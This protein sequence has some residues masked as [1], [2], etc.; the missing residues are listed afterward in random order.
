L[1]AEP[2]PRLRVFL[3]IDDCLLYKREIYHNNEESV[4]EQQRNW[5]ALGLG[6]DTVVIKKGQSNGY[7]FH[8]FAV[9]RPGLSEFLE[10]ANKIADLYVFSG[11][12]QWYVDA[13]VEQAIDP[14]SKYIKKVFAWDTMTIGSCGWYTKDLRKLGDYYD[15]KRSVLIDNCPHNLMLQPNN[16][17]ISANSPAMSQGDPKRYLDEDNLIKKTALAEY[18]LKERNPLSEVL[19]DLQSVASLEDVRPYLK[20]KYQLYATELCEERYKSDYYRLALMGIHPEIE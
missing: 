13:V 14:N 20:K 5:K 15:P 10:E 17:I 19:T 7:C 6:H 11:M 4:V 18:F 16:G 9:L 2:L 3:D 1:D 12:G 8:Y